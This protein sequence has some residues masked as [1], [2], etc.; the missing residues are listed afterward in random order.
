MVSKKG[1][2]ERIKDFGIKNLF[3]KH[4]KQE[5]EEENKQQEMVN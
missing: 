3:C 4:T 1:K 5:K 2:G